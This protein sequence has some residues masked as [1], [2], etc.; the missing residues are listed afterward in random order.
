MKMIVIGCG[1]MGAGLAQ[2]LNLQ[3]HTVAVVDS[4]P[5]AFTR[6]GPSFHGLT[7][8]GVG[9]DRAVLLK[10]GIERADGLAAV[11]GS[12]ETN[13]V[14]GR[15]AGQVF[16]V[17]KVVARLYDPRKAEIYQRLGLQ[18]ITPINWGINRVAE[19]LSF[20]PFTTTASLGSGQ[21]DLIEAEIPPLLVGRTVEALT[22][23]G[24]VHVV[25]VSRGGDTFLPNPATVLQN[26]DW[27][28][29]ALLATSADRLK[30]S[31]GLS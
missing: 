20:F 6:L 16:Q 1:R 19:L 25:A 14:T 21:V 10:A 29:L 12:D 7:V 30:E 11:T 2:T 3:G 28:H 5:A 22:I 13:V 4:D 27:L 31:L 15:L 26:G 8:T 18:T 17:P 23:P 9:F 24:E